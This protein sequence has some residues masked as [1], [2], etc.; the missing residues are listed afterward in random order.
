[1][2]T[3]DEL[4][5]MHLFN[6]SRKLLFLTYYLGKSYKNRINLFTNQTTKQ[7]LAAGQD[8]AVI[9]V[10]WTKIICQFSE[11]EEAVCANLLPV[12]DI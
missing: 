6:I 9:S 4:P 7:T 11:R 1:M 3:I 2:A 12:F 5:N 8:A 10:F